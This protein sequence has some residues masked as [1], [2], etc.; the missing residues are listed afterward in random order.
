MKR[1]GLLIPL[2]F[3]LLGAEVIHQKRNDDK[4]HEMHMYEAIALAKQGGPFPAG[5]VIVDTKSG[6][7]LARG[8]NA[9]GRH[10]LLH[11]E[12]DAISRL[13]GSDKRVDWHGLALYTTAEPCPMCQ[14]AIEWAGISQ[15]YYGTPIPFLI[16][17][18]WQQIAIRAAEVAAKTPFRETEI[19]GGILESE[20]NRLYRRRD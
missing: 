15:V 1:I 4:T 5:A 11:A 10:P 13:A 12:I 14:A 19:T 9:S 6:A 2:L 20:C 18:G 8:I 16:K 7:V 17:N 3:S